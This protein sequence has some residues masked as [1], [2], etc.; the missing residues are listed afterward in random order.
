MKFYCHYSVKQWITLNIFGNVVSIKCLNCTLA[1]CLFGSYLFA[2]VSWLMMV[3]LIWL[4]WV[5]SS[6]AGPKPTNC[7]LFSSREFGLES[8]ASGKHRGSTCCPIIQGLLYNQTKDFKKP[9]DFLTFLF[10]GQFTYDI[11]F[12]GR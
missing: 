4:T 8:S 3:C 6:V 1:P 12:L 10:F 2:H 9:E 11:R 5:E 7:P